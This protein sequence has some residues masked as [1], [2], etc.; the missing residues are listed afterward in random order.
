[1]RK[2]LDFVNK[3][4]NAE[5]NFL[6]LPGRVKVFLNNSYLIVS[7]IFDVP[8]LLEEEQFVF[9]FWRFY[10]EFDFFMTSFILLKLEAFDLK[11]AF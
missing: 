6:V 2:M 1:M 9:Q 5:V 3:Y 7:R 11:H 8:T 4:S 10:S